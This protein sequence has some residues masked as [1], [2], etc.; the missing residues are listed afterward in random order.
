M[1]HAKSKFF[2]SQVAHE[3]SG[4]IRQKT[5][6]NEKSQVVSK[7]LKTKP[8]MNGNNILMS[9]EKETKVK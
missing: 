6:K 2:A 9:N 4:P 1:L 3:K 8:C 5:C 7:S